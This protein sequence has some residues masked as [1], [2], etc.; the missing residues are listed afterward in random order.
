MTDFFAKYPWFL[1][2]IIGCA[3][4]LVVVIIAIVVIKMKKGDSDE[5]SESS[6][7]KQS[8]LINDYIKEEQ[9]RERKE[10]IQEEFGVTPKE[11]KVTPV[12]EVPKEVDLEETKDMDEE[13][14]N[15]ETENTVEKE[16]EDMYIK[17]KTANIAVKTT[18]RSAATPAKEA[19]VVTGKY[20]VFEDQGFFKYILKASNGEI[21]IE[22]KPYTTKASVIGAI[23]S[24]KRNLNTGKY[25]ISKDKNDLFQF[26]LTGNN[27][28]PLAQS[29]NYKT[30]TNAENALE[31][32]KRFAASSPVV[33]VE[34][35]KNLLSEEI[36]I[37]NVEPKLNGKITIESTGQG[38]VFNLLANNNQLLCSSKPYT[39]KASCIKGIDT[40][41]STVTDGK[42]LI[43]RD[44]NSSYQFKLYSQKGVLIAVGQTYEDKQRAINSANSVAS[45]IE[46][47]EIKE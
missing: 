17:K 1:Y 43:E 31:S 29:A 9:K 28:R 27:N 18:K 14:T 22:S 33:E 39:Q 45:F 4:L 10:S 32:F 12:Q 34:A 46:S 42:W 3:V 38:F 7:L 21:L 37:D 30:K 6:D 24:M 19:R 16:D 36:I 40:L 47:A 20:E 13:V 2:V 5:F 41:R 8:K 23:D 35:P 26:T 11:E 44:K 25:N 15:I